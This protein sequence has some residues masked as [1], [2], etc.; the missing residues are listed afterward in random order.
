M[1]AA[2]ST[3]DQVR[4]QCAKSS[5]CTPVPQDPRYGGGD[6]CIDS[7]PGGSTCETIVW[8]PGDGSECGVIEIV[9]GKRK[10]VPNVSADALLQAN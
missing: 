1:P 10:L 2:A 4:A 5:L 3:L 8:C 7:K 9:G 6:F